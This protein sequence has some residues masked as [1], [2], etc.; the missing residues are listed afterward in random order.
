MAKII[1]LILLI[2][3]AS[4]IIQTNRKERRGYLKQET[5]LRHLKRK[6]FLTKDPASWMLEQIESDF[7]GINDIS[8][9]TID[10]NFYA[11][12]SLSPMIVRY[13]IVDN[14]LY[15]YFIPGE[16]VSLNDN[17]TERAIK[18][19]LHRVRLPNM[20]FLLSYYDAYP[21]NFPDSHQLT[22]PLFVSAKIKNSPYAILIPDW[23]SIGHWW[24]SDIKAIKKARTNWEN[25]RSLALW[26]GGM[27]KELRYT[28]CAISSK[29][30]DILDARATAHPDF[31]EHKKQFEEKGILGERVSWKE[32]LECKY[33]PYVD[34]VMCAAPALQWRLLSGSLTFKPDSEEIQWFYRALKP[35]IHYVPVKSDLSD[36]IEKIEWAKEHDGECKQIASQAL[37]FAEENILYHDVLNY[38]CLTLKRYGTCQNL[39]SEE[40]KKQVKQDHRWV[41]INNRRALRKIAKKANF[42]GYCQEGTP[43]DM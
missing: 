34:G 3:S 41:K 8:L 43:P 15:R 7:R 16:A 26:R 11:L 30:R 28:L 38:F 20:D 19:I 22:S 10:E 29:N 24:M 17:N 25:K 13:R 40:L 12:K 4:F 37:K 39:N 32:F 9:E 14:E 6:P 42:V 36:L 33:L 23:R 5:M 18:T 2:V 21:L 27:T 1:A 35:Y 31:P